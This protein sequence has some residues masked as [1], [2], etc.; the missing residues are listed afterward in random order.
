MCNFLLKGPLSNTDGTH[1]TNTCRFHLS[2]YVYSDNV[3]MTSKCGENKEVPMFLP[4]FD[5]FCVI[6]VHTRT[7]TESVLYI[8][9]T[10]L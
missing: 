3:G 5:V 1:S 9:Y 10:I 4:R 8:Y 7:H 6:R 2:V